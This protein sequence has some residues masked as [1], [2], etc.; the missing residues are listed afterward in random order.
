[1][2]YYELWTILGNWKS[3]FTVEDFAS[4]FPSPDP[5]KVLSDMAGK[6]LLERVGRGRYKTTTPADYVRAKYSI[7]EAYDFLRD[8]DLPYALT[9]ADGV[10]VWTD[11]GYN[12]NRFFGSYPIYI[13][14]RD[15]DVDRW[16]GLISRE[17]RKCVV[18]TT[19]ETTLYGVY[20]V[21]IPAGRL[22]SETVN[23]LKV[24]PLRVV[25]EFCRS[26]PYVYAPALEML[27]KRFSL[28]IGARYEDAP[29]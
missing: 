20:F 1:M 28:G 23:G 19:P 17:G 15:S 8:A 21:I 14:V 4:A 2:S 22:E 10:L 13:K 7:G 6:R 26:N 9:D 29:E 11:G 18:G 12:A 3:E 24:D 27:D 16:K 5:R 25:V